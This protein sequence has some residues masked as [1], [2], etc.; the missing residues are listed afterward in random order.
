MIL[1]IISQLAAWVLNVIYAFFSYFN[2][3]IPVWVGTAINTAVG[4]L[5]VLDGLLPLWPR[6]DMDGLV[7]TVGIMTIFGWLLS[8]ATAYY[9]FKL[10][11]WVWN[12]VPFMKAIE[13]PAA[14]GRS[15]KGIDSVRGRF[16]SKSSSRVPGV[17][18]PKWYRRK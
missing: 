15:V 8:M 1:A 5:G 6:G 9:V 11:V 12:K 7:S 14:V 17:I 16:A 3:L 4:Y 18:V 2:Y 13:S 10:V